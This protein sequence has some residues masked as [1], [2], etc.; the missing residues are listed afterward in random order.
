VASYAD[1]TAQT[2]GGKWANAGTGAATGA[3]TMI[4]WRAAAAD[5]LLPKGYKLSEV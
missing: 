2:T 4:K 5:V 1:S 3:L